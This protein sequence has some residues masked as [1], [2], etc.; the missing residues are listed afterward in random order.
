GSDDEA[1]T[2]LAALARGERPAGVV[3]GRAAGS[4]GPGKVVWVFPGQG[5]QRVG[6]GSELYDRHPVFAR[7][8]DEACT[9]LDA[10]LSGRVDHPVRDVVLGRLSGSTELLNQTL[11]TQAGLFAVETALFRLVESWGVRPDAVVGHSVG[12]IT[13]AHTAGVLSLA[14]A[15][16]LVA[17]RGRMMQALPPG[18]AMVAVAASE[19]ETAGLLGD[20]VELAAVNGPSSVV[21]SGDEDAVL[22]AA[23]KLRERGRKTK[24]LVVSHAFHSRRMEPMLDAF[25]AELAEVE[26]HAPRIP[27][28]SNVT[29]R[30]AAPEE[31]ASAQYWASHVRRPVRFADGIAAAVELGGALFVEL[32]PGAALTALVEETAAAAGASAT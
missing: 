32:G 29:G 28:I 6:M 26:W 1:R 23:G 2:A 24:R 4:G 21:L 18:G 16:R 31:L 20:G 8:L 14:D 15:A 13:A 3:T 7:A 9:H 17:A 25:A 12:E 22:A 30:L 19:E 27:V 10:A 11:F 5:S